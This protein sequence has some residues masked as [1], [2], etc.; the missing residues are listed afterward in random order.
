[1]T[2]YCALT[3]VYPL[4]DFLGTL[5]D[6]DD[7]PPVVTATIPSLTKAEALV[8]SCASNLDAVLTSSDY[9]LPVAAGGLL[10]FLA[11]ANA[12]G[13]AAM[14]LK[15]KYPTATG[16]SGD[17]GA[18]AFWQTQYDDAVALIKAGAYAQAETKDTGSFASGFTDSE[19]TALSQS[20][21]VTRIDR[22]TRF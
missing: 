21:L 2:A 3:D 12:Y 15:A 22:E 17:G 11:R 7:G 4:I 9:T 14:I 8:E 6:A 19:G 20:T 18:T 5:R 13:A 10:E 16:A 1:M